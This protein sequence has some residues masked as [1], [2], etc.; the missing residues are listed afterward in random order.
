MVLVLT[1]F[2]VLRSQRQGTFLGGHTLWDDLHQ[3]D[4]PQ[5][6][7]VIPPVSHQGSQTPSTRLR[8]TSAERS[9]PGGKWSPSQAGTLRGEPAE[10]RRPPRGVNRNQHFIGAF[11]HYRDCYK[12]LIGVLGW[13]EANLGETVTINSIFTNVEVQVQCFSDFWILKSVDWMSVPQGLR[14]SLLG[15]FILPFPIQCCSP[16]P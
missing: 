4:S 2:R 9:P 16:S 15:S 5:N 10:A 13:G 8:S 12:H 1:L 11:N 3:Q 14:H 7:R 6:T